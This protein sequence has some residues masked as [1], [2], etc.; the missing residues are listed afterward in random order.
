M[1]AYWG[2]AAHSVYDMFSWYKYLNVILVFSHTSVFW[3]ANSFLIAPFPDH[4]LLV[5]FQDLSNFKLLT[6]T[7]GLGGGKGDRRRLVFRLSG[8]SQV[9]ALHNAIRSKFVVLW[10]V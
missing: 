4:C 7:K 5:H 6:A 1:A 2:T 3:S 9:G 8:P 10:D